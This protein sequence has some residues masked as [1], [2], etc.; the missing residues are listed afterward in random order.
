MNFVSPA[1][2]LLCVFGLGVLLSACGWRSGTHHHHHVHHRHLSSDEECMW[3]LPQ[4][5]R[6]GRQELHHRLGER[7]E[8]LYQPDQQAAYQ[9]LGGSVF[10]ADDGGLG[11]Y[12]PLRQRV[13]Q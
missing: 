2:R 7:C 3:F 5:R 1:K 6:S 4:H 10:E 12:V 11:R 13:A 9:H 8:H